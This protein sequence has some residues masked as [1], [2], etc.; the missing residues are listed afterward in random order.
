MQDGAPPHFPVAVRNH[1]NELFPHRWIGR[2]SEFSWPPRSPD[3]NPLDYYLWGDMK[4][5]VYSG[6]INTRDV[7]LARIQ[8]VGNFI[9]NKDNILFNVRRS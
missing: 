6:E 2:D 7:L 5:F 1:L 4:D 9:R 8:D 3:M